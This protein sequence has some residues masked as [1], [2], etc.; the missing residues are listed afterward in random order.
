MTKELLKA[1]DELRA[2][3]TPLA[4]HLLHYDSNL[5]AFCCAWPNLKLEYGPE[6]P[7]RR[8][9][10]RDSVVDLRLAVWTACNLDRA[11]TLEQARRALG[12]TFPV[13]L[14]MMQAAAGNL[15]LPDGT[16]HPRVAWLLE[17]RE[18]Q[19]L[20]SLMTPGE[21]KRERE[22]IGAD[23]PPEPDPSGAP[24]D[25]RRGRVLSIVPASPSAAPAPASG[26]IA[27]S[28]GSSVGP[29]PE[30]LRRQARRLRAKA[31]ERG[32]A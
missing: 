28:D 30:S 5:R 16:L 20:A 22:R 14:K 24:E 25:R 10:K 8:D 11:S 3:E 13:G 1:I 18:L 6:Q 19:K 17:R 12:P 32:G 15:V 31:A 2:V 4:L 23:D 21:L 7:L 27:P 29:K 26:T 9:V